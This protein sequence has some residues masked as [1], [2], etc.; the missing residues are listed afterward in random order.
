M[1]HPVYGKMYWV[2]VIN[3][4]AET[5]EAIRPLLAESYARA[6]DRRDRNT[7]SEA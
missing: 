5:F 3:P 2:C 4:S 1:P 7:P 6:K